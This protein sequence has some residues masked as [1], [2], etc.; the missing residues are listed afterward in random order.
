METTAKRFSELR[1]QARYHHPF[2]SSDGGSGNSSYGL[3]AMCTLF[4]LQDDQL[5]SKRINLRYDLVIPETSRLAD[6]N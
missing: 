1:V 5:C 3:T 6:G 2:A 4:F